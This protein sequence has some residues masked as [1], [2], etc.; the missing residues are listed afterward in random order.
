MDKWKGKYRIPSARADWWDYTSDGAYFITI[1]AQSHQHFFGT[2]KDGKMKMNS[3]GAL[4]QG[5]WFE[6]PKHAS[7]VSLGEFVVM[8]NHIHGILILDKSILADNNIDHSAFEAAPMEIKTKLEGVPMPTPVNNKTPGENRH[9]NQGKNSIS[10]IV[11]GFK[12]VCTKNIHLDFP[13]QKFEWQ[14]LFW[15]NIITTER[16]FDEITKYIANNPANWQND[17]FYRL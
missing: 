1:C 11:G 8:P 16:S 10:S 9:R 3:I 14:D 6:I 15:D 12:S 13:N 17:K 2:C 4:V 5:F 7:H